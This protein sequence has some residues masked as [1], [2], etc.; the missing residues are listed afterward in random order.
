MTK[1]GASSARLFQFH[2]TL[3]PIPTF[4]Y[5]SSGSIHVTCG[6]ARAEI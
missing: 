6:V 2:Q 5:L 3:S 1:A 4:A